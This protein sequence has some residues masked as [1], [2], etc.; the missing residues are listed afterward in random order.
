MIRIALLALAALGLSACMDSDAYCDTA[1]PTPG[2]A[3]A[4]AT[5]EGQPMGAV[6]MTIANNGD[7]DVEV[8][9]VTSGASEGASIHE[10]TFDNGMASMSPIDT[11]E[12][13]GNSRITLEPGGTHIML[14]GLKAPLE[15]GSTFKLTLWYGTGAQQ[16][17]DVAVVEASAR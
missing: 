1:L 4:R 8:L 9:R 11:L 12:I 7:C 14:E 15:A 13:A 2:E 3:W 6:Y 17:V 10:T 16:V 5:A